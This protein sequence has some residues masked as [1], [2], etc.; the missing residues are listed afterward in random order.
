MRKITLMLVLLAFTGCGDGVD[1]VG[2]CKSSDQFCSDYTG[3]QWTLDH[4]QRTCEATSFSDDACPS[5]GLTASCK[6]NEGQPSERIMRMYGVD[7]NTAR[8]ACDRL[9]GGLKL[10]ED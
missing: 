4:V 8:S 9:G 7:E 2:S 1:V 5:D 10:G 6:I 3:S